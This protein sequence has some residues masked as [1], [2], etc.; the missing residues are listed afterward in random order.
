MDTELDLG[1]W[2]S[3]KAFIDERDLDQ[4]STAALA[5][6]DAVIQTA[7]IVQRTQVELMRKQAETE[8]A[9]T[10]AATNNTHPIDLSNVEQIAGEQQCTQQLDHGTARDL[11]EVADETGVD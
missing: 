5:F 3:I 4:T 11:S 7:S 9:M 8:Q 6:A 10:D 1:I 2:D